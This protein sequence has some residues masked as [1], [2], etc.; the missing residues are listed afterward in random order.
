MKIALCYRAIVAI[1]KQ[2][3]RNIMMGKLK[4]MSVTLPVIMFEPRSYLQKIADVWLHF[5]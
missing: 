2:I 5:R 3:G 4:L 1:A